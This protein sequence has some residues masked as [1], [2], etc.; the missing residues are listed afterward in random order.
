MSHSKLTTVAPDVCCYV[1]V[2]SFS[3]FVQKYIKQLEVEKHEY[4]LSLN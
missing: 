4:L 1:L 2:Q 3:Q